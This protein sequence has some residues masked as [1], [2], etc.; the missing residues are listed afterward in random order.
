MEQLNL[1]FVINLVGAIA[2]LGTLA[3]LAIQIRLSNRLAVSAIEHQLN[4]RV[5]DRRFSIARDDE[6]YGL[7]KNPQ[8]ETESDVVDVFVVQ[9]KSFWP[10][11]RISPTNLSKSREPWAYL[12]AFGLFSFLDLRVA[13]LKL[14]VL[15]AVLARDLLVLLPNDVRLG[16]SVL[17]LQCL[18]VV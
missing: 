4:T 7:E 3:Y 12:M 5:Y 10:W 11:K 18:L 1:E 17:E 8:I 2:T 9:S 13:L 6:F 16:S 15:R 14:S